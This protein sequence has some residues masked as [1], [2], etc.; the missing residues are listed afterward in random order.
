[1]AAVVEGLEPEATAAAAEDAAGD[2]AEAVVAG[3]R[4]PALLA[5]N[6]LSFDLCAGGCHQ[7]LHLCAQQS[8]QLLQVEFLRLSTHED[9]QLLEATLALVPWSLPHLRSLVLKGGQCRDA[10]GAC[11][12]GALTTLPAGLSGLAR[13]A[14]LDLSF[15]SLETLPG[16]VLQMQGLDALL[17]SHNHLSEL[18]GALGALPSLT[19]LTVT[20]NC[21]QTLPTALGTLST[22]QRLDLSKNLLDTLPPEIGGL[23][24]LS[25][26]NLAS[27]RLQSLPASLAGLRSLRLLVL[28]SNL[29]ASVPAGLARLPLLAR[30]DL[31][32][33]RLRDVPPELLDAPFVRLQGNPLGEP[34]SE[35]S[36]PPGISPVLEMPRLFLTSDLDSF[37]VTPQGCSVTL[38][39]GVRLQFP[40]GATTTPITVHY[41]L[42]LPEP[43]LVHLGPHDALLSGVLELQPHRVAFQQDVGLWLLFV[44]PRARR[45]REVVVRTCTDNSWDDLETHL[46]EETP[47]RL[48]AH[49]QVPHF[50][51]FLVVSRPV[52]NACLVTTEGTLLCSSGHPGV[53]VTFP[54]G[55][56][57]EP[58]RVSMQVVHMASRELQAL[59]GEPEAAVSP[60][61]CL[62]QSGP[63]SFLQPVT[64]Q[65]PLPS[66]VTGLSLDRSCLHLLY[67]APPAVTWDDITAQVVLE[68]THLYARFQVTHFSWLV[69][70]QLPQSPSSLGTAPLIPSPTRYWL[71]YT[72]KTCVGGLARKAW[73]RLRLHRVNLIALQRRR[74]PE[75]VL[76][77]CLPQNKVDATLQRLLERYRGPEPSDTVEM[78][79]GEKFFAAFERG[80]YVDADRPDCVEGRICFVFYS[81][82][83]NVKEVYVTT[84]LDREAQAVR[85]QVS[86][87]RG[88]VPVQ[89]PE[90]AEAARRKKGTNTLWMATLLIKLPRL[91]GS[92]GH[93][94]GAS[95]SLAP[96]N[97]GDAEN[98][99]LTQSN[100]LSV[101]G[102]LGVD[103]PAVALHLGVPYRELQR[104]RHNFRDDLDG[105]IRHMLFSWAERQAGQPGA[106]GLLVQAL[107][108]S[109]RQD[110]AEEVRAVLEL[111][112]RKYQD[113]IRRTGLVPED[114]AL[115][116][117]S[118]PQS[119]EPAQA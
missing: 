91:R 62:S 97:L 72:T 48:W 37:P 100:L 34:L 119:P 4:V 101:A 93:G 81:H 49:C 56:T 42:L 58:R 17:L 66:G 111:G 12:H 28:H 67:W 109:D 96:L 116:S 99:F 102:R 18:P 33:N 85:G 90:E 10:L 8:P 88:T 47:K 60:L 94:W 22:L 24:S 106:V 82:L 13:L 7:L 68:L 80:I 108:Q 84:T 30:L 6:R 41:R 45:C 31:R 38:A 107:E 113:G 69:F 14:H 43:G 51:W 75:Q 55:A 98:G 110:V 25:E 115:P 103:W 9:P 83:K 92:E 61:L 104:I 71:W 32:D 46:K 105:Q 35:P 59:L 95:P 79:E 114:P 64:V 20:H 5:G 52:S 44:P 54:P 29:L 11:I 63:P 39:C 3:S 50:S 87:Y 77:Q 2:A 86:F 70:T 117:P 23:S 89:V 40:A 26:L 1:M 78:F 73:E 16:C 36:S 112:R 21:L 118:A 27:N 15:N 74:D 76:L 53:K 19:F 57:E 65:L